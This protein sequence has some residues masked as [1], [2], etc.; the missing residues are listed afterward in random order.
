MPEPTPA[1]ITKPIYTDKRL[2]I[3]IAVVA[4]IFLALLAFVLL[5]SN[6]DSSAA[7]LLPAN[8]CPQ[9][10]T[11][12]NGRPIAVYQNRE[13]D[14]SQDVY[15]WVQDNCQLQSGNT[16]TSADYTNE[17]TPELQN[18]AVTF[19]TYDPAT[20]YAGDFVLNKQSITMNWNSNKI[21][22]EFGALLPSNIQSPELG[23]MQLKADANILAVADGTVFRIEAQEASGDYAISIRYSE[24][25]MLEYD[26]ITNL[27]VTEGQTVKAGDVIGNPG[28]NN[29]GVTGFF[30]LM[31]KQGN[32]RD[33]TTFHCPVGL[34]AEDV[35]LAHE[36]SITQLMN[37]WE[38]VFGDTTIYAQADQ[39][40][41]GCL[42]SSFTD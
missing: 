15:E 34:L 37:D 24:N 31:I 26:H 9:E 32:G 22:F 39:A 36:N 14:M 25:W 6:S 5:N 18:L 3:A 41:A 17:P 28:P 20:G 30:E 42:L 4:T 33:S 10:V 8:T 21:M 27:K 35:K 29:D 13:V 2:Y 16:G 19:G 23:Y 38:I 12:K 7:N 1:P 40:T 11:L